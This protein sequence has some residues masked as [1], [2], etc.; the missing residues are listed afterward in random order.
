MSDWKIVGK[1]ALILLHMQHAI[2]DPE[3]RVAHVGHAKAT[4]ES[5][6]LPKQQALLGAFRERKLPVIYVNAVTDPTKAG[7]APVLGRFWSTVTSGVNMPNSKDIEVI[8][9]VAPA[10]GEPVIGNFP[11]SMFANNDLDQVLKDLGVRTL[12]L[13]GVAT[14]MVVLASVWQASD[15]YYNLVVPS[16]ASSGADKASCDAALRMINNIAMVCP[17]ADVISRLDAR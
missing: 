14:D 7:S 2:C 15:L 4:H 8:K 9:E 12:V 17:T 13:A 10:R 1:P 5:G 16:D 11:F 3:G 6:I